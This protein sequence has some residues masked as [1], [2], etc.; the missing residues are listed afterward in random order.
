LDKGH[1]APPFYKFYLFGFIAA[2]LLALLD[3][4]QDALVWGVALFFSG[5]LAVIKPPRVG[6]GKW[7]DLAIMGFLA[8]LLLSFL[9][10]FYWSQP[11]WRVIATDSIGIELPMV[12]SVQPWTSFEAYLC[13]VAGIVWFYAAMQWPVNYGGRR[14]L[15]FGL[16][17]FLSVWAGWVTFKYFSGVYEVG[18]NGIGSP[19]FFAEG[20]QRAAFFALGGIA[21]FA[22][23]V[24]GFRHRV[25]MPLFGLPAALFCFAALYVGEARGGLALYYLGVLSWTVWSFCMGGLP[26][27]L[28]WGFPLL[29]L[30]VGVV[31][32]ASDRSV[33]DLLRIAQFDI[34][35]ISEVDTALF[36]DSFDLFLESPVGGVG[37][38]VFSSVFPQ[39]REASAS[40]LPIND[41]GSGLLWFLA[42]GGMFAVACLTLALWFHGRRCRG[43]GHEGSAAYRRLSMVVALAFLGLCFVDSPAHHPGM[44]YFA[45]LFA[46]LVLP[47]GSQSQTLIPR[48]VWRVVGCLLLCF[49]F[50][51]MAAGSFGW[52]LHSD[53]GY[54]RL[55]GRLA[56]LSLEDDQVEALDLVEDWLDLRPLDWLAYSERARLTLL[57][58]DNFSEAAADFQRARFIEPMSGQVTFEEGLAWLDHD[59]ERAM[60]A[61]DATLSRELEDDDATFAEMLTYSEQSSNIR[62]GLARISEKAPNYRAAWLTHLKG[63]N[64]M[65]EL[66]R[67]LEQDPKLSRFDLEQR[68]AIVEN[69]V[70]QGDLDSAREFVSAYASDLKDPWWLR[71]LI[72]KN[73]A[74]FQS[75]VESI[76]NHVRAPEIGQ[77]VI[78]DDALAR[79]SRQ[80]SVQSNDPLKGFALLVT[81]LQKEDYDKALSVI[82]AMLDEAE[83]SPS[84]FYWRGE[85]LYQINE[86]I[87][88]WFAFEEYQ[89]VRR[90][91]AVDPVR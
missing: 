91:L 86:Y 2:C 21:T 12:L 61:W 4:R 15:L 74:D 10:I 32:W 6:L 9:P 53:T 22:Y 11:D 79:V 37:L 82:D 73:Q 83:P 35:A 77:D 48:W 18:G 70:E 45:L 8:A 39:Y 49:S 26:R 57:L 34:R 40:P 20:T 36:Q 7:G 59:V 13:V 69:W 47:K 65:R 43:F 66:R 68:S 16:S 51:W 76:R 23:A 55:Q 5:L 38:G 1:H 17:I 25:A 78:D 87:E 81:Y 58:G 30:L 14:R 67:E 80:F 64:L 89:R 50:I 28:K 90:D 46:V 24:E 88:S 42:E 29:A 71:A 63:T 85:S 31:A 41:P 52:P 33:S 54:G 60:N 56:S 44:L 3:G 27:S 72:Y 84:L 19:A 62:I 75:A